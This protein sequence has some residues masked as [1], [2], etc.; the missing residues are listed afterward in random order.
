VEIYRQP[1]AFEH[2]L[3]PETATYGVTARSSTHNEKGDY[4]FSFGLKDGFYALGIVSE[5]RDFLNVNVRRHLYM[6][7]GLPMGNSLN[8]YHFCA[9]KDTFVRHLRQPDPGGFTMKNGRPTNPD[10]SVPSKR[11][12][13]QTR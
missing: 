5:Q 10:G 8:P 2:V 11:Y 7:A 1:T 6:L 4:I 12:L 13:R 9:F 3:R